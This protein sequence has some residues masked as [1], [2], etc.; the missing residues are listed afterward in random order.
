MDLP[1]L[2]YPQGVH[3]N[4]GNTRQVSYPDT[5]SI[6]M[7]QVNSKDMS[8]QSATTAELLTCPHCQHQFHPGG[9]AERSTSHDHA[10]V[11]GYNIASGQGA[12]DL[13][14]SH[15]NR[16]PAELLSMEGL[17]QP[18]PVCHMPRFNGRMHLTPNTKLDQTS[19]GHVA[20]ARSA[21]MLQ[22]VDER[23][24]L[25]APARLS[26]CVESYQPQVLDML[27]N[28]NST[29]SQR[30]KNNRRS[31]LSDSL[32]RCVASESLRSHPD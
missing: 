13:G 3:T 14:V 25:V 1:T 29:Q 6:R 2:L 16:S 28:S 32:S 18:A 31:V 22:S 21:L 23:A 24:L 27:H 5:I 9:A 15:Y 12:L 19:N 30:R 11:S 4:T 17:P 10:S 20:T 26:E 8:C 7:V